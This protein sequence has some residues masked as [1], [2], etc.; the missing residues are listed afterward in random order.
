MRLLAIALSLLLTSPA[1]AD[2]RLQS[3]VTGDEGRGWEAVGRIDLGGGAFCTGALIAPDLVLT[4]AHC[5]YSRETGA[6]IG[7][8]QIAFRAGWRNGRAVAY[9]GAR[10][11]VVHPQYRY[12][13][14][15][16]IDRITWDIALIEL[17][18]PIRLPSVQPFATAG[19][20]RRGEQVEVV[21]YAQDRSEAPSLQERCTV[22]EREGGVLMLSCDADFGASGAPVFARRDGVLQIV[23]VVSAIAEAAGGKVSLGALVESV[24]E[25]RAG[26]E[27]ARGAA[28]LP[29]QLARAGGA[30]FVRP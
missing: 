19:G 10:R 21:S 26:L 3:L 30:K 16:R 2:D 20:P 22:L 13:G 24:A 28:P 9:R 29:G 25:L 15:D 4:A 5:L 6:L 12:E 23:S 27:T 1:A 14:G 8:E 17:E 7:A 11:A 18:Q